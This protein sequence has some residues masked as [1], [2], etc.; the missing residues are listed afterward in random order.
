[1][2]LWP[3]LTLSLNAV[4]AM[5]M[6]A[7]AATRTQK[8]PG[9]WKSSANPGKYHC[10]PTVTVEAPLKNVEPMKARTTAKTNPDAPATVRHWTVVTR[11]NALVPSYPTMSPSSPLMISVPGA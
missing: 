9:I 5:T 8:K 4:A 6:K 3:D 1:M 2:S 7:A 10:P 11:E